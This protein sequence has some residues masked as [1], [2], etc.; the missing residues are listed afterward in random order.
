LARNSET[1][2]RPA[3]GG[4]TEPGPRRCPDR[5]E[6]GAAVDEDIAA[7]E[8]GAVAAEDDGVTAK[9]EAA[10]AAEDRSQEV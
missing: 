5:A 3:A 6:V 2:R 9:E 10:A 4:E 8:E 1:G 7:T